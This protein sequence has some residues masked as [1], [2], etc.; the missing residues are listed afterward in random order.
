M[1]PG[2][3]LPPLTESN[4]ETVSARG[5]III[6]NVPKDEN[7]KSNASSLEGFHETKCGK[8]TTG[9]KPFM[10]LGSEMMDSI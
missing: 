3:T 1:G 5:N 6:R 9:G 10:E 8:K 4:L 2:L 7:E